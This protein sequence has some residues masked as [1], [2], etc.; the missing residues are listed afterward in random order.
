MKL[1]LIGTTGLPF[2]EH[3]KAEVFSFLA[4]SKRV[5]VITAASP[6]DEEGYFRNKMND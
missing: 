5:G 3:C 4:L 2:Y 1:L 6:L